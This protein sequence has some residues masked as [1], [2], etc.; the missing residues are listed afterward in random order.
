ML[1]ITYLILNNFNYFAM[2]VQIN[3]KDYLSSK[4]R[5]FPAVRMGYWLG[6]S[7]AW[8]DYGPDQG[9]AYSVVLS[10][11]GP[12]GPSGTPPTLTTDIPV[13]II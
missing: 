9:G 4:L 13:V 3:T 8:S 10:N 5:E 1:I 2:H 6:G 12:C 7:Q 11:D